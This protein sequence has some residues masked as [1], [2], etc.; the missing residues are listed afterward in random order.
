MVSINRNPANN[1]P[2]PNESGEVADIVTFIERARDRGAT[3]EFISQ[4]LRQFGWPQ[5]DIERAFFEVYERFTGYPMP[6]PPSG[7]SESA[8]D[9]FFYLLSFAMLGLWT[10]SLGEIAF[11]WIDRIFPDATPNLL[12]QPLLTT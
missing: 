9:A 8:K 10:Y 12:Q 4:L 1:N 2:L 7:G 5:R 11:I 3:D 6:T